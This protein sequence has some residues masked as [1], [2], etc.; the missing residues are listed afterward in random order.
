MDTG[1]KEKCLEKD[2]NPVVQSSKISGLTTDPSAKTIRQSK[3]V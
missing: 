3:A 2:S 1:G